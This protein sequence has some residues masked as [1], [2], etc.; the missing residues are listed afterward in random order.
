MADGDNEFRVLIGMADGPLTA[1]PG[2]QQIDDVDNLVA[3]IEITAGKQDEFDQ[4]ETNHCTVRLNDTTGLFDP[5]NSSSPYFGLLNGK[6]LLVNLYNPVTASWYERFRGVID[7]WEYDLHPATRNG[8]SILSNVAITAVGVFDYLAGY[9]LTPG[10]DGDPPPAGS[11]S[12]VFYEDGEVDD[13]II[14]IL[15]N[16]GID[17]TRYVVFSGNVMVQ[18]TKY[19][20]GDSALVAVRDA[21]DAETPAALGNVYEDR[22]GRVV[23]HGRQAKLTPATVAADAGPTAWDFQE[24]KLGDGAAIALDPD[25]AQ[26]RPPLQYRVAR[27]RIINRALVTARGVDRSTI[28]SLVVEDA[29]SIGNFGTHPFNYADS[30]N[31]GHKTN[32]DT[33]AEDLGRSAEFLVQNYKDPLVR[34]EA[35]TALAIDPE[36]ARAPATWL[37]HSKADIGDLVRVTVGYPGGEGLDHDFFIEGWRQ[38]ITPLNTGHDMVELSLNVSPKPT[39]DTYNDNPS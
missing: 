13:R 38:T 32:G 7:E 37:L 12:T 36:D 2:W 16:A 22:H 21:A 3:D 1:D 20:P 35:L 11:E 30:I 34:V 9:D 26:V 6:Q 5:Y 8:V 29:T 18:E 23:F 19:D 27:N 15:T 33:A 14:A 17:S 28:P 10:V 39:V 31:A 4:T 24:W 25:Y